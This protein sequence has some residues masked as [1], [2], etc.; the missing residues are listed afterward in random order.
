VDKKQC[1]L[2]CSLLFWSAWNYPLACN[3]WVC[4]VSCRRLD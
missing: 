4:A 1:A 2:E 3:D